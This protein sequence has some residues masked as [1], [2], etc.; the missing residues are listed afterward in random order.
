MTVMGDTVTSLHASTGALINPSTGAT[1][2][3][4]RNGNEITSTNSSGTTT[5]YDT[6]N[7]PVL[8][9]AGSGTPSSPITFTY[10]LPSGGT[11]K[12]TMNYTQYTV[13][14]YFHISG[15]SEYGATSVPLVSSIVLADGVSTYTFQY[16]KTPSGANCTPISGTYAANCVTARL[17]SITLPTGGQIIYAYTGG[18]TGA[19]GI[20]RRVADSIKRFNVMGGGPDDKREIDFGCPT[21]RFYVWG[22]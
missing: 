16:E 8:T 17:A 9:V 5:Y 7:T 11:A 19:Y 14:T 22:F 13:A 18:P 12:V 1:N 6:L 3:T 21:R 10:A 2:I 20:W 15:I 4:D